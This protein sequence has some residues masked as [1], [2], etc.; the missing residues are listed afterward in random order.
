MTDQLNPISEILKDTLTQPANFARRPVEPS[1]SCDLCRGTG[2]VGAAMRGGVA[3]PQYCGCAA[4]RRM[5]YRLPDSLADWTFDTYPQDAPK[6]TERLAFMRDWLLGDKWLILLG[7]IGTGKTGLAV[8]AYK[9]M[10]DAGTHATFWRMG[11]LLDEARRAFAPDAGIESP[12]EPLRN[13]CDFLVLDDVGSERG[14]DWAVSTVRD[15]LTSRYE[16]RLRTL[17]TTNLNVKEL[18]ECYGERVKDRLADVA[19]ALVLTGKT[20]RPQLQV[21]HA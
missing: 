17:I 12:L 3:V 2:F 9:A 20:L 6:R 18:G 4:G 21:F 15:L 11:F 1:L 8:S 14:T 5:K 10:V 19:V 13:G 7:P 16:R